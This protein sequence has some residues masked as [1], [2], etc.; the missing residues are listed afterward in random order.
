MAAEKSRMEA[1]S[2]GVLNRAAIRSFSRKPARRAGMLAMM[3][4]QASRFSGVENG[5]AKKALIRVEPIPPEV[6]QQ[7]EEGAQAGSER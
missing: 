3:M 4:Y 2:S 5:R 1:S 7:R 6:D